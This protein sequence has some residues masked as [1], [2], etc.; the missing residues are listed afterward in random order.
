M[1]AS[2]IPKETYA[3]CTFQLGTAPSQFIETRKK[4][5]VFKKDKVL[6]T[7]ADK[8]VNVEFTCK[9]PVNA[10]NSFLAFGAGLVVAALLL[11]NPV[12]WLALGCLAVG[13]LS[14]AIG[15]A[16]VAVVITHKCSGPLEGGDWISCHSKVLFDG[17]NAITEV[18]MLKCGTG[19]VLKAFNSKAN[20]IEAAKGIARNNRWESAANIVGS[21]LGGFLLPEALAATTAS[22][23]LSGTFAGIA[24][25]T[26]L[27]YGERGLLRGD[28][29]MADNQVYQDLNNKVDEN[30]LLPDFS[31]TTYYNPG[32]LS[33][34]QDLKNFADAYKAG[35]ASVGDMQVQ[36]QLDAI[37]NMNRQ[38]LNRDPTARNLLRRLNNGEL[39]KLRNAMN[40]FNPRRMNPTMVGEANAA[41][42][43]SFKGNL[44]NMAQKGGEG[45][46]FFL[47]L[48]G[49]FFSEKA[50]KAFA[51]AA[52]KDMGSG[53]N[54]VADTPV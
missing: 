51:E 54:L 11:S 42:R 10:M 25:I 46:L 53:I 18:S 2:Y 32:T 41:N 50:R 8:N 5:T 15:A 21:G 7:K 27:T 12:G 47:P 1:S 52:Q 45:L 24:A 23:F 38:Q 30:S 13:G 48:V 6:L 43:A 16:Y 19:G 29:S 14:I 17:S 40:R 39:P 20:V 22:A 9:S 33:N 28:S 3:V 31:D 4:I 44:G 34:T 26:G 49:T 36:S 37:S 35:N